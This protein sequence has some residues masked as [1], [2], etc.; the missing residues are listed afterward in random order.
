MLCFCGTFDVDVGSLNDDCVCGGGNCCFWNTCWRRISIR[1]FG[2]MTLFAVLLFESFIG[3]YSCNIR[4][5]DG[6]TIIVRDIM[7]SLE[8]VVVVDLAFGSSPVLIVSVD[9]ASVTDGS[10]RS[11][12]CCSWLNSLKVVVVTDAPEVFITLLG[13]ML[14]GICNSCNICITIESYLVG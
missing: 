14:I 6:S 5:K 9:M 11:C 3:V 10:W 13:S 1:L 2:T 12:W 8:S 4:Y 7:T